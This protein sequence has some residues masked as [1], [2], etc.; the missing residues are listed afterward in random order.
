MTLYRETPCEHGYVH[1]HK[2]WY[3][4]GNTEYVARCPGG[5][6]EEVTIN[7]EAAARVFEIAGYRNKG[8]RIL[9]DSAVDAA[10]DIEPISP[11]A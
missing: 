9:L 4:P 3:G 7:H 2:D 1:S 10:L 11:T 8:I 6:R 5:S